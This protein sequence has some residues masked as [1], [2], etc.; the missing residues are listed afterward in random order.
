MTKQDQSY[1]QKHRDGHL[2]DG[3]VAV[4]RVLAHAERPEEVRVASLAI[5]REALFA[6]EEA[7]G[8]DLISAA[9]MRTGRAAQPGGG[10]PAGTGPG[11][12]QGDLR[13]IIAAIPADARPC[14]ERRNRVLTFAGL[15]VKRFR[16]PSRNQELLLDAFEQLGWPER[17][18]DPLPPRPE[19]VPSSRLHDTVKQ[20]NRYQQTPL[21]RFGMDGPGRVLASTHIGRPSESARRPVPETI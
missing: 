16:H 6:L 21:L 2:H 17:M 5:V 12:L 13:A 10:S 14:W 3:I 15:V 18:D 1:R 20:L 19:S 8:A 11:R 4:R 9:E 7:G